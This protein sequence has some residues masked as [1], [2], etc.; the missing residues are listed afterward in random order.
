MNKAEFDKI[1]KDTPPDLLPW[2]MYSL[3]KVIEDLI[4][5]NKLKP[6]KTLDVGCGLGNHSVNLAQ[7]GFDVT[8]I[9]FSAI[10]IEKA[11]ENAKKKNVKCSFKVVDVLFGLNEINDKFDFVFDWELLHHI[12]PQRRGQYIKSIHNVL[13]SGAKYL[14]LC[15]SEEDDSFGNNGKVRETPLG[16]TLYF[17]SEDEL[18]KLFD[19]YFNIIELKTIE[20]EGKTAPHKAIMAFMK[21]D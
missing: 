14:S 19:P 16:T 20:I 8:G 6:C 10:A 7:K 4:E 5:S 17:S 21:K 11:T 2:N 1:Y 3:P 13:N 12:F 9:D 18:I 15:F